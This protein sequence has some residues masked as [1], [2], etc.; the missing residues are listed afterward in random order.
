FGIDRLLT[1]NTY[2]SA[3]PLHDPAEPPSTVNER[4]TLYQNWAR[5]SYFYKEQPLDLIKDYF[6]EKIGIY[7]VFLGFY[8]EMLLIAA[9]VGLACL[10][11][12]IL[13]MDSNQTRSDC[14]PASLF[15]LRI[16]LAILGLL[17]F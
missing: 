16:A 10:I 6:G 13:L 11:Y 17:F 15:L 3:Y 12:G 8:T 2:S 14:D 5:F 9:V 4:Y 1:S 7:F